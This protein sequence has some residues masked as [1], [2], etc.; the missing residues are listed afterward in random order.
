MQASDIILNFLSANHKKISNRK[1][2]NVSTQLSH[3]STVESA[4]LMG[5]F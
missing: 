5:L 2:L 3:L 4:S 1:V